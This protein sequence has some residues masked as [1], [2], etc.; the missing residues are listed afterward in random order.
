M[1]NAPYMLNLDCDM[2]VNN[3]DVLLQAMCL[4]LHPTIDKEYAFVQFPQTFYNG[5]KDDPFGNQWIVTMQV[6]FFFFI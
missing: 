2:F 1:T 5:L 3:P 4:L 6:N